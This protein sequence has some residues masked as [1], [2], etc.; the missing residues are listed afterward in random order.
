ML[1]ESGLVR[2]A[3]FAR[4]ALEAS[5]GVVVALGDR[6]FDGLDYCLLDYCLLDYCLLD[7]FLGSFRLF[8]LLFDLCLV[9]INLFALF[10]LTANCLRALRIGF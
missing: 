7:F 6:F 1:L 5:V 4:D 3:H 8:W 2:E 10:L 9:L